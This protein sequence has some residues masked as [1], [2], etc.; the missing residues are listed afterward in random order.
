MP[1]KIISSEKQY[2]EYCNFFEK[3]TDIKE[4]TEDVLD[5]IDLLTLLIETYDKEQ[6]PDE[7]KFDPVQ[8]LKFVM[9]MNNMK[10]ADLAKELE[11]SKSLI[12]DILHYRRGFSKEF[13]R[14]L[15][16]RFTFSQE[17][18]NKP[19]KLLPSS[20]STIKK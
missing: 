5:T 13:I 15:G 16:N 10:A 11:V 18:W 8:N 2:F 14:K 19:Y 3:L 4:P 1:Y 7:E 6:D 12:S 17:L 9:D 20:K